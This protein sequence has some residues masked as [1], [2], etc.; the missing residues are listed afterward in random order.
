MIDLQPE[1]PKMSKK[2]ENG[3]DI[4]SRRLPAINGGLINALQD[5]CI[6]DQNVQITALLLKFV[7]ECNH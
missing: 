3:T 2:L 6:H 5:T 7:S 4:D 1:G